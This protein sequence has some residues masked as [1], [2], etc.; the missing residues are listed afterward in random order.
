MR[1]FKLPVWPVSWLVLVMVAAGQAPPADP[2]VGNCVGCS[3]STFYPPHTALNG[4]LDMCN[5]AG[6]CTGAS[7]ADHCTVR[8][9][10]TS[11]FCTGMHLTY[12]VGTTFQRL[13]RAMFGPPVRSVARPAKMLTLLKR[14][15][16]RASSGQ[17]PMARASRGS[18]EGTTSSA[19]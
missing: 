19:Y 2:S 5:C 15:V 4:H 6:G 17:Q 18:L 7:A 16:K 11:H 1:C 9:A 14:V 10:P 13:S 3:A 8:A 12:P